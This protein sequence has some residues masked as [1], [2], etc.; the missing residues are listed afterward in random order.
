MARKLEDNH[1][2]L[3]KVGDLKAIRRDI[4]TDVWDLLDGIMR[5]HDDTIWYD[6][7]ITAHEQLQQIAIKHGAFDL[8]EEW[9]RRMESGE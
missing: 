8:A 4:L 7:T 3:T 1:A 2:V 6:T 5:T 9:Q